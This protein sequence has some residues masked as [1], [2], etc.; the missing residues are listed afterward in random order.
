MWVPSESTEKGAAAGLAHR[1]CW[2]QASRDQLLPVSLHI[3]FSVSKCSPFL[4]NTS[5]V[6]LA[7]TLMTSL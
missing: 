4:K 1:F 3:A 6:G 7:L 5:P 2:P